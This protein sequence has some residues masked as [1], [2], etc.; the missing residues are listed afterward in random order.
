M[1][2]LNDV[3]D[4]NQGLMKEGGSKSLNEPNKGTFSDDEMNRPSSQESMEK[5]L[6]AKEIN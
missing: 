6:L 2:S 1:L 4:S 3:N 5:A